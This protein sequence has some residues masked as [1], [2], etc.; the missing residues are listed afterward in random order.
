LEQSGSAAVGVNAS[1]IATRMPERVLESA[2]RNICR[3]VGL[4]YIYHTFDSRRSQPGFP[5]LVIAGKNGLIMRELK[6]EK[7]VLS[8]AQKR[9]GEAL[10]LAGVNYAVWRPR[11]LLSGHIANELAVIAGWR[12]R[13][14][15]GA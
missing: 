5:D 8:A 7:G 1:S 3:D 6:T 9:W 11:D 4:V 14:P 2:I 10:T 12:V 13:T 15:P